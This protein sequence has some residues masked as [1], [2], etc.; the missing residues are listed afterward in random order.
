MQ[1]TVNIVTVSELIVLYISLCDVTSFLVVSYSKYRCCLN[2]LLQFSK[3]ILV[4][5]IEIDR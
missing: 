3:I 4:K 5:E 1:Q 2:Q